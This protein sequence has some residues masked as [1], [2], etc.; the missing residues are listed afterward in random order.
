MRMV[1]KTAIQLWTL[2][3]VLAVFGSLLADAQTSGFVYVAN[4]FNVFAYSIDNST[5]TLTSV[6]GSPFPTGVGSDS[7]TVRRASSSTWQMSL[8]TTSPHI[9]SMTL[10][11][12]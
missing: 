2:V 11:A 9:T 12:R 10:A 3:L 4:Y 7:I 1:I 6:P 5:G 8:P